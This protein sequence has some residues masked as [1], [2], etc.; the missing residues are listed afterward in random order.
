VVRHFLATVSKDATFL[1]TRISFRGAVSGEEFSTS[2]KK[3]VDPGFTVVYRSGG[4]EEGVLDLP[5]V[6]E[7]QRCR[8]A[9]LRLRQGA[10]SPPGYLTESELIGL[11]EKHGVG[12][13][14][15]I[16]THINNITVRSYVT[17]GSGR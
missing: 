3:E 1:T 11:M 14:A 12:T 7:G 16:P 15:S 13:D 5:A 10:T 9:S 6:A 2:G 4:R 8:V 17:L